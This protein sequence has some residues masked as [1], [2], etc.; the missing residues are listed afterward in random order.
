MGGAERLTIDICND[1]SKR[2][3]VKLVLITFKDKIS[4]NHI[5]PEVE[6]IVIPS[7]VELSIFKKSKFD[8]NKL[9]KF[10]NKFKPDII[11]THLFEAEITT[12]FCDYKNARWISHTHGNYE[13]FEKFSFLSLFVK[14]KIT[15]FYEKLALIRRY[16]KNGGNIFLSISDENHSFNKKVFRKGFKKILLYNGIEFK[17]FYNDIDKKID[18]INILN[19]GRLVK[20]KNQTFL[21][22]ILSGLIKKGLNASLSIAGSGPE[23]KN[24]EFRAK[25][26]NISKY[27]RFLG[28]VENIQHYY[29]QSNLYLHTAIEEPFGLAII[30]AMASGLPVISTSRLGKKDLINDG[31]NGF[32]LINKSIDQIIDKIVYIFSNQKLFNNFSK[33][34]TEIAKQYDIKKYVERLLE[35]YKN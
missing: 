1:L 17:N 3:D 22:E 10:I 23:K 24:I 15:N 25:E 30:E 2:K 7:K 4:Y 32:I 29:N 9:Q 35:I 6:R 31:I 33:N 19:V 8:I 21:L 5:L 11:H 34:S 18:K 20:Y 28:N 14:Y 27:V 12:R 26:L 13:E 16:K